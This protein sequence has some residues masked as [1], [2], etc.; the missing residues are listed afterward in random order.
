MPEVENKP[1][2]VVKDK[3]SQG[4]FEG[5][6]TNHLTFFRTSLYRGQ[7]AWTRLDGVHA[8]T[9]GIDFEQHSSSVHAL[10]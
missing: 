8:C 7:S 6:D 10:T 1:K 9:P 4:H 2:N 5:Q 3:F